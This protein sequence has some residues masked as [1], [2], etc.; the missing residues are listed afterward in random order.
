MLG[1]SRNEVNVEGEM[2]A[3]PQSLQ[4]PSVQLGF[5]LAL[6]WKWHL[7]EHLR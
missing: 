4:S 6:D 3:T 2:E 5:P 1:L 7:C